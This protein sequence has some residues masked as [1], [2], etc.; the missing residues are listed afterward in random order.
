MGW[1]I[2]FGPQGPHS[3]PSTSSPS[4]PLFS[5]IPESKLK[6]SLL[7]PSQIDPPPLKDAHFPRLVEAIPPPYADAY[8]RLPV[9][10]PNFWIQAS[11]SLLR[12]LR[13]LP[14]SVEGS[15]RERGY[16]RQQEA[17]MCLAVHQGNGHATPRQLLS[18]LQIGDKPTWQLTALEL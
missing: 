6:T 17:R 14:Q 12:S 7:K 1:A 5:K 16:S 13:V 10:N 11:Q 15:Q 2:K 4:S 9:V 8:C 3:P 18:V